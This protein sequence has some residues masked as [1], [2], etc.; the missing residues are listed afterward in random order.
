MADP[1]WDIDILHDTVRELQRQ[2]ND[3][4]RELVAVGATIFREIQRLIRALLL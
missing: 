4:K 3:M 2:V 1:V